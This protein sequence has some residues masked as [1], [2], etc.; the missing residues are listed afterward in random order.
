[1]VRLLV[2]ALVGDRW[3]QVQLSGD[4]CSY[5]VIGVELRVDSKMRLT[6]C[7][8]DLDRRP[9]RG[10][11]VECLHNFHQFQLGAALAKGVT[12]PAFLDNIVEGPDGLLDRN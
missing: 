3:D 4:V 6:V 11:P 10:G 7:L 8:L 9:L 1:M 5:P 2:F 12:N